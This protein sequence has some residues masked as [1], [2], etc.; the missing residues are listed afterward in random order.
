M[1]FNKVQF[2]NAYSPIILNESG[3][4]TPVILFNE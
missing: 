1:L 3:N 4:D 2:E